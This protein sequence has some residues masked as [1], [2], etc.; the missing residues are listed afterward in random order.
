MSWNS[1]NA[2]C[3]S[4]NAT[5]LKLDNVTE[6][7]YIVKMYAQFLPNGGQAYVTYRISL[8]FSFSI[9][10]GFPLHMFLIKIA[11][12]SKKFVLQTSGTAMITNIPFDYRWAV[13]STSVSGIPWC[14]G[15]SY[16]SRSL[17]KMAKCMQL[18]LHCHNI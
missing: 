17:I 8:N 16:R 18:F 13:D 15:M 11:N 9:L 10:I 2:Y 3:K 6:Y 12:S 5:L 14:P 4:Y 1:A 7:N